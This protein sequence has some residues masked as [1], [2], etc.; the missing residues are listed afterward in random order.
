MLEGKQFD[1]PPHP[2]MYQAAQRV[3]RPEGRQ[4][5]LEESLGA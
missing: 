1:I 2:A 5:S 4:G 3:R